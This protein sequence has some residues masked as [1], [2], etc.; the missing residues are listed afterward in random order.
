MIKQQNICNRRV[1]S[2][3]RVINI[4]E[5][6]AFSIRDLIF[7]FLS[8]SLVQIV[9]LSFTHCKETIELSIQKNDQKRLLYPLEKALLQRL[10]RIH[11]TRSKGFNS[12]ICFIIPV[13]NKF[14]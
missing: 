6:G 1:I 3:H 4:L 11:M 9:I 2:E 5:V 7:I 14:L 8:H 13:S 10:A 12:I